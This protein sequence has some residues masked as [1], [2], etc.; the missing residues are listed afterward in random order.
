MI[1][2]ISNEKLKE[3]KEELIA[4]YIRNGYIQSEEVIRAFRK[5]PREFFI[6]TNPKRYAYLDRPLGISGNQTISAPHMVAMM[7]SKDVLDLQIG[8]KCLEVGGGSGYHAAVI[9]EIIAP[10]DSDKSNWGHIFT[11]ERIKEL[12]EFA[13]ENLKTSKYDDRV[14][15]IHG[16]GSLGHAQEA[17]F[18]KITV[19]CAA[20]EIPPPLIEQLKPGG[21]LVIP[22]GG[23]GY[24]QELKVVYK[25]KDG[26]IKIRNKCGVAFVPLIG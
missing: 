18:D 19:A 22:V 11:I 23:R 3:R 13:N 14:T 26:S 21:R 16:D 2:V 4:N 25:E 10:T 7:V 8:D 20:P 1:K 17:P 12:V 6:G 24:Y 5:V 9:A 15:V